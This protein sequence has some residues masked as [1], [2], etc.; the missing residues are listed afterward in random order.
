MISQKFFTDSIKTTLQGNT[1]LIIRE[2][3]DKNTLERVTEEINKLASTPEKWGKVDLQEHLPRDVFPV[4]DSQLFNE[5]TEYLNTDSFRDS[6]FS[7]TGYQMSKIGF[8]LWWDTKGYNLPMHF[9]NEAVKLAMQIYIGD[10][11][12]DTLGTSFGDLNQDVIFT[13][14][15]IKNTGYYLSNPNEIQHGLIQPVPKNFNRF[16]LYFYIE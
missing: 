11:K 4:N 3:F 5:I 1:V 7:L 10:Q 16:S 8:T 15:Y 12:H 2:F 6:F 13:L 14:P 9:D